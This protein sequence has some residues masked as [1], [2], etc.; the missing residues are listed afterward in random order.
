MR[1]GHDELHFWINLGGFFHSWAVQVPWYIMELLW[2]V[3]KMMK[4][5]KSWA[6]EQMGTV[7]WRKIL[8]ENP[9]LVD[10]F[11]PGNEGHLAV[12]RSRHEKLESAI[13]RFGLPSEA[14]LKEL[15]DGTSVD[16]SFP[17]LS[18]FEARGMA[19][20]ETSR[21]AFNDSFSLSLADLQGFFSEGFVR[22]PQ[23]VPEILVD[24]AL[25]HINSCLG[26]GDISRDHPSLIGLAP[27]SAQNSPALLD[28]FNTSKGSK[29]PTVVQCLLGKGRA[30]PPLGCQVA[31]KFPSPTR[32]EHASMG[33]NGR[34]WHVDGFGKGKHSP[35]T[36]LVGICLSDVIQPN[37]G[38]L[39]VHPGAHWGLQQAV[40]DEVSSG[41]DS[42]SG[43]VDGS[44][45]FSKKPDLGPPQSLLLRRGDAIVCHQKLPHLGMPNFSPNIRY[46]VY[47]RVCHVELAQHRDAWLDDLVLPFEGLRASLPGV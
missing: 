27:G 16:R 9:R 43:L 30:A 32:A 23:A 31:L 6:G 39:A 28:L 4:L 38:E 12:A 11:S 18:M 8:T 45:E 22:V 24:D 26:R 41:S 40:R 20:T 44:S 29:L 10:L 36:L 19:S 3:D 2:F 34:G 17:R 42:F 47:F 21:M 1:T 5:M 33:T 35:F 13:Q 15:L 37:S 14:L 25:R 7:V 46:Q